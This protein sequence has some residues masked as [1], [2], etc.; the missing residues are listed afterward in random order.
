LAKTGKFAAAVGI[1]HSMHEPDRRIAEMR[2]TGFDQNL[3][4]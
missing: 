3:A 4:P 1:A 2:D